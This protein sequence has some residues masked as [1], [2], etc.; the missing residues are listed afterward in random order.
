MFIV[1]RNGINVGTGENRRVE[2]RNAT[3]QNP[4]NRRLPLNGLIVKRNGLNVGTV[5]NRR[6]EKRN[7]T[8]KKRF[9]L[10]VG[11]GKTTGRLPLNGLIVKRNGINVGTVENRR[12]EKR[13]A[14]YKLIRLPLC[15][16]TTTDL[17][18][19]ASHWSSSVSVEI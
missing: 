10:H 6:V 14:T 9:G 3:Y 12:V 15:N 1:K 17:R 8:Y 4:P 5:E 11:T 2:N 13:N 18:N 19:S 7:A 16:S